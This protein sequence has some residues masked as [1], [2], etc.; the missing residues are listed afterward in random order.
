MERERQAAC[1]LQ[2]FFRHRLE[3]K[4]HQAGMFKLLAAKR[5]QDA[6]I[7]HCVITIQKAW[8]RRHDQQEYQILLHAKRQV[9]KELIDY[10][11][12]NGFGEKA[13]FYFVRI[14]NRCRTCSIY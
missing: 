3:W 11:N 10:E 1:Q 2:H 14:V 4:H 6:F 5:S 8:R 12:V 7:E 13:P 9:W